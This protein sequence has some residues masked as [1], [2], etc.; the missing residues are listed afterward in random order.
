MRFCIFSSCLLVGLTT[1]Y[2][3]YSQTPTPSSFQ[4]QA[5]AAVSAGKPFSVVSLTAAAEWTAGSTHESGTAQLQAKVDGSANVQLALGQAS[6]TESQSTT[7]SSKTCQWTDAAGTGNSIIGPNCFIAIPWFAPGLFTQPVSQLPALLGTT[8]DGAVSNNNSTFH[9]ISYLLNLQGTDSSSTQQLI[10]QSKVRVL[11]DPQTFLPA[12]LE[13]FIHPD[14]DNLTNLDVK[15]VF[16]NYQSVSGI[17]L[18]FKIEK[19]VHHTLQLT[20]N[21]TN[22]SIE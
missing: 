4:L 18:P 12:S 20:L 19:Y 16:S 21:I 8:D 9:Q 5:E 2:S 13:Y 17:M 6:R 1:S 14:N 22:A 3:A 11:Y 7:N 15:V 10:D